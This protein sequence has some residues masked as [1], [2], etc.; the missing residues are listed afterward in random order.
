MRSAN[1]GTPFG[2]RSVASADRAGPRARGQPAFPASATHAPGKLECLPF[3]KLPFF[4]AQEIR[5]GGNVG[6]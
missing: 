6:P 2:Q 1:R 5:G 4:A 3:L